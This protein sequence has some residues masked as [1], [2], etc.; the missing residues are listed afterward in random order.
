M[1]RQLLRII[2]L[3]FFVF[4]NAELLNHNKDSVGQSSI[5]HATHL[6]LKRKEISKF[7]PAHRKFQNDALEI[8]NILRARHCVPPLVLDEEMNIRAQIYAEHLAEKD[9]KLTHSTD[10]GNRFGE[11]LYAITRKTPITN[12]TAEKVVRTW[13]EEIQFYDYS[14]PVYNAST[15]HFTQI[16]WRESKILGVG[17]ASARKGSKMFV[18]AQYGPAGNHRFKFSNNVLK[19]KC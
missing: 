4:S 3:T 9:G 7:T 2:L 19:P 6:S 13:Y 8:H 5:H 12:L 16:V 14:K 10:L 18:V 15:S 1:K 11:N 17:Y